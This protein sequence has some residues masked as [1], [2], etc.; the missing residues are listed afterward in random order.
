MGGR[1]RPP[2]FLTSPSPLRGE[3]WGGGENYCPGGTG[4][5]L[6][7]KLQL[8]NALFRPS[9]AWAP[10]RRGGPMW[11][12]FSSLIQFFPSKA[13]PIPVGRVAVPGRAGVPPGVADVPAVGRASRP[14]PS[15]NVGW[16][17]PPIFPHIS[18]PLEGARAGV[19][20]NLPPFPTGWPGRIILSDGTGFPACADESCRARPP[21]NPCLKR[22]SLRIDRPA[23]SGCWRR[24]L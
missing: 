17:P 5:I 7:P 1:P 3:G 11:P 6:V 19:G 4:F 10:P 23:V 20:V 12:P 18:L 16:A 9:S 21:G 15:E 13:V 8:G 2:S 14:P 22:L 24:V